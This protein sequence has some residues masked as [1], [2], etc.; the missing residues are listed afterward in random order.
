MGNWIH[1]PSGLMVPAFPHRIPM[2]SLPAGWESPKPAARIFTRRG[3]KP[4]DPPAGSWSLRDLHVHV[5][6]RADATAQLLIG[7]AILKQ[8]GC[9]WN[10][11]VSRTGA[12]WQDW[13]G[14]GAESNRAHRVPCNPIICNQNIP[15]IAGDWPGLRD[16]LIDALAVTDYLPKIAN[17]ADSRFEKLGGAAAFEDAVRLVVR[18]QERNRPLNYEAYRHALLGIAIAGYKTA[19][20][21]VWQEVLDHINNEGPEELQERIDD[22]NP[23]A[24]TDDLEGGLDAVF[25]LKRY[26]AGATSKFLQSPGYDAEL[27]RLSELAG[28]KSS[29][30]ASA[31]KPR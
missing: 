16:A 4:I 6:G 2:S 15:D 22:F 20:D 31:G 3:K 14:K 25:E 23:N 9:I 8:R 30:A 24:P 17:H 5:E 27:K 1:R 13:K 7:V 11:H 10:Y 19:Y 26:T 28:G 29:P 21:A 18:E 12:V